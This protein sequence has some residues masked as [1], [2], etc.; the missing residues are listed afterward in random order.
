MKSGAAI[1]IVFV[2]LY[3]FSS[4]A[5]AQSSIG[6]PK[7]QPTIGGPVKQVSPVLPGNKT[8]SATAPPSVTVK[9]TKGSCKG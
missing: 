3:A 9:C 5:L 8:G 1:F 6:G 2:G 7:K 4:I